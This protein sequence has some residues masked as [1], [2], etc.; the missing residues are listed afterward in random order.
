MNQITNSTY[1]IQDDANPD[2]VKVTHRNYLIQCFT[3]EKRLPS[4]ITNYA[5]IT[6]NS[7]FHKHSVQSQ[8]DFCNSDEQRLPLDERLLSYLH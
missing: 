8:I 2:N 4:L 5:P 6:E 7:H 1:K 3:Q